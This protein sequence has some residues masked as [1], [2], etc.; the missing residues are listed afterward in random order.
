MLLNRNYGRSYEHQEEACAAGV[1]DGTADTVATH[2]KC[3]TYLFCLR[4][5]KVA[6]VMWKVLFMLM[7]EHTS[8]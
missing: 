8:P 6:S 3:T 1:C 4:R 5:R 7:W 2:N